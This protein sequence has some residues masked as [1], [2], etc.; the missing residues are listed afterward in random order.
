MKTTPITPPRRNRRTATIAIFVVGF[1]FVGLAAVAV[2]SEIYLRKRVSDC[3][4]QSMTYSIGSPVEIEMSRKPM[5]WQLID[6][7]T[8][9]IT[10]STVEDRV[11][12]AEGMSMDLRLNDVE[13]LSDGP[14]ANT[15]QSSSAEVRWTAQG[16]LATLQQQGVLAVVSSVV[17]NEQDQTLNVQIVG[18]ILGVTIKPSVANGAL[19]LE[20]VEANILGFRIPREIPQMIIGTIGSQ[21]AEFPLDMQA[22]DVAVT[23]DGIVL[24]LE[25]G[26]TEIERV[27]PADA[28]IPS[29]LEEAC[30]LV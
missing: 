18:A 27:D 15:V 8:P 13:S 9:Y 29:E 4:A 23:N 16:I 17:P 26:Y 25:G 7:K 11:G 20:V 24:Q 19:D 2:G 10:I 28:D 21:L 22:K 5:V 14:V 3:M 30:T 1:L 6:G 12:D